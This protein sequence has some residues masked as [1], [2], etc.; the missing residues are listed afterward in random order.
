MFTPH[1]KIASGHGS[2]CFQLL[3]LSEAQA[4]ITQQDPLSVIGIHTVVL[5]WIA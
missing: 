4:N 1:F 5:Q 2:S 3:D